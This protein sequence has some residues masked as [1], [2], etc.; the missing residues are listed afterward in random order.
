MSVLAAGY[1]TVSDIEIAWTLLAVIGGVFSVT[2]VRDALADLNATDHLRPL[3]G[4]RSIAVVGLKIEVTRLAMQ[5]I[6]A[7]IGVLAMLLDDQPPVSDLPWR[8]A[9]AGV[10]IRWGLIVVSALVLYQSIENRRLR[11]VLREHVA[12]Q[13]GTT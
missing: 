5:L 12:T 7:T 9:A 6:F 11:Q 8:V 13:G 3:N 1:G 2:N 4:R 10:M